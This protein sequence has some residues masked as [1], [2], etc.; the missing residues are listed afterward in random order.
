MLRSQSSVKSAWEIERIG[1]IKPLAS[2]M[3][4]AIPKLLNVGQTEVEF[5][6]LLEA[7]ARGY[8]HQGHS[9]LRGYSLDMYWGHRIY[10]ASGSVGSCFDSPNGGWGLNPT[11]PDAP[12]EKLFSPE[13]LFCM[14]PFTEAM[15]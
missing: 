1:A 7:Y 11:K 15:R 14:W 10:G 9:W 5:A 12:R 6:G 2:K 8:G 3:L 4:A 13:C